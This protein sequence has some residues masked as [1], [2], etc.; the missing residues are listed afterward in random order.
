MND[1]LRVVLPRDT[2]AYLP[3][4]TSAL[5]Y[6][7]IPDATAEDYAQL[8]HRGW[9]RHGMYFFRPK[10]ENCNQC[11][12]L[13]IAVDDFRPTKSQRRNLKKNADI[14]V[15]VAR[16]TV[17]RDHIRLFNAYHLDM[18]ERRDWPEH[19]VIADEYFQSFLAGGWDF[20]YEFRY[21]R[22]DKLVGLGL[23]DI[24]P[25][26]MSSVYF[27]HDPSWRSD[28]PGT[29]SIQQEIEF[30]RNYGVEH[31][32]L[33][34]WIEACPSMTYKARFGPHEV[35]DNHVE[36]EEPPTWSLPVIQSSP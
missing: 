25:G 35:L 24:V 30:A 9:R 8:L 34:Y 18:T 3:E 19:Q 28:G 15:Q 4:E 14:Q 33:G 6:R 7:V 36:D 1:H 23:V 13:R 32:Y 11:R 10:C 21:F 29:F 2:C 20:A 12:S 16:A 5:E 31:V 22:N 17:T 26:A 27:F